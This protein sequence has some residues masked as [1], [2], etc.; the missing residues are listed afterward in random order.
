M[1]ARREFELRAYAVDPGSRFVG[2]GIA[3]LEASAH[4][5]RIFVEQL[6]RRGQIVE[7][8]DA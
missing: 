8:R 7:S 3:D 5:A 2:R 1:T 4:G 6:R